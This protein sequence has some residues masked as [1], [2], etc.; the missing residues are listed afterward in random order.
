MVLKIFLASFS[1]AVIGWNDWKVIYFSMDKETRSIK[2]HF[3]M[4]LT[5]EVWHPISWNQLIFSLMY[6]FSSRKEMILNDLLHLE[7][8]L[9][10]F[11]DRVTWL[12]L[13]KCATICCWDARGDLHSAAQASSVLWLEGEI[14]RQPSAEGNVLLSSRTDPVYIENCV[15]VLEKLYIA[16]VVANF[17]IRGK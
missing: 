12:Q 13:S 16:G 15:P 4:Y 10:K 11:I 5:N 8:F 14:L 6:C 3:C 1:K 2:S 7:K 17:Q 9:S